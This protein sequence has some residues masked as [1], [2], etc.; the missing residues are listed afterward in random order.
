M[1]ADY[2]NNVYPENPESNKLDEPSPIFLR[3]KLPRSAKSKANFALNEQKLAKVISIQ[4]RFN[5]LQKK[6]KLKI[7][8]TKYFRLRLFDEVGTEILEKDIVDDEQ[9]WPNS[10]IQ[11][12][13]VSSVMTTEMRSNML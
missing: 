10:T 4:K 2:N 7:N 11:V 13:G 5:R 12:T 3:D 9:S 8:K 1:L 6:K